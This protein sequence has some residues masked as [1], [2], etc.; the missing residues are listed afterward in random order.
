MQGCAALMTLTEYLLLPKT[1]SESI[2]LL[3]DNGGCFTSFNNFSG[4]KRFTLKEKSLTG[5]FPDLEETYIEEFGQINVEV[6]RVGKELWHKQAAAFSVGV[7][8]DIHLGRDLM[9]RA[10]VAVSKMYDSNPGKIKSLESYLFQTFKHFILTEQEKEKRHRELELKLL[11]HY[12]QNE[13]EKLEK[14]ILINQLLSK[15]D[16]LTRKIFVLRTI[17][18]KYEEMTQE[19]GLPA[20][21]IRSIYSKALKRLKEELADE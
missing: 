3:L 12:S 7:L 5:N 19:M 9:C 1:Y 4:F 11:P 20:N 6:Y 13:E 2:W 18:Y 14:R 16:P 15:T 8:A 17:G 10:I 21:Q